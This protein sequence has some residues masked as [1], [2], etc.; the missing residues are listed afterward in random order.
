MGE[1]LI[2]SLFAGRIDR[3]I[4]EII[5]VDQVS[6]DIVK[7]EISEYVAT[8]SIRHHYTEIFERYWETLKR[9]HEGIAIWI[10]GFFG[11]GKSS[12]AKM[13]GLALENRNIQGEGAADLIAQRIGDSRINVLLKNIEEYVPTDGLIF[14]VSTDRGIRSG[15]QTLTEIIYRL[16]LQRLGYARD[17][18]LAE[19]EITLEAEKRLDQ[20]KECYAAVFKKDWDREK[21]K[22]A[23]AISEAS[24]VMQELN[25]DLYPAADSWVTAAKGRADITPGML[26]ERC[27]ELLDRRRPGRSFIFVI[28]E[29]GQFVARDIQKM[30]DLQAIVQSLGRVGRGRMWIAVTSQEKLNELVGGLDDKRV[31]LARLR[32]RFSLEVHLEPSD[33]SE[34]TGKRVLSKK[35]EA[36][37][38]LRELFSEYR[39][40]LTDSTRLTA[41]VKLPELA[42]ESFIDLYPLLPYQV[43]LIIQVVSG[44]RTQGGSSKH[45]GG[46]NR[47]IIKLA[48]QIL[49][50]PGVNLA[51]MP[52]GA[53]ARIDQIYDL[54]AGNIAS[55]LRSKIDHIASQIPHPLSAPVAKAICLLQFVKSIHRTP[56]NI[57]ATLHP[58]VD[59]DSRLPE[60]REALKALEKA[61]MV[62][63]GEDGY[64]IP[65][66]AEDDWERQRANLSPKPGDIMRIHAE[67]ASGLWQPQPSF[68]FLKTKMFKAGLFFNAKEEVQGDIAF[69][70]ALAEEGKEYE[71]L[72][73]Q[74]RARSQT[75]T[76]SI[77]WAGAVGVAI[78]KETVEFFRSRE[79]LSKKERGAQTKDET[80]LV[81]EERKALTRHRDELKRLI[82]QTLLAG[83][84]FFRGNERNPGKGATELTQAASNLL[85]QALP[86]VFD[87]FQDAASQVQRKDLEAL[88]TAENL[89][90]LTPVF[91]T[92]RLIMDQGGRP[93]FNVDSG[94][95]YEVMAKIEHRTSY[96]ETA[97]GRYLCDEFDRDPFGWD[98]EAVRLFVVSL[99]R[100]GKIEATS[101]G[102]LIES[103][104]SVEAQNTFIN[105]NLFRQ[106]SFRPKVGLEFIHLIKAGEN[107]KAAF[108]KEIPVLE[109]GTAAG[110]IR[111]EVGS[112]EKELNEIRNQ[113]ASRSLPGVEVIQD[114]INHIH[115]IRTGKED[116]AI[117]EF[118][119]S[120]KEIK[121]AIKRAAEL[122]AELTEP[123]LYILDRARKAIREF[124]PFLHQEND[125]SED[126]AKHAETLQDLLERETFYREF[127]DIEK[128]C[129][130]VDEEYQNRYKAAAEDRARKYEAAVLQMEE[131]P[132]WSELREEQRRLIVQPL[133]SR[134]SAKLDHPI[135]VPTLRADAD[136]VQ[137]RLDKA[138]KEMML[139]LEGERVV[140]VKAS[141]FFKGGIETEEQLESALKGLREECE[142]LIGAGKKILVN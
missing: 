138:I 112:H 97:S 73:S 74:F 124:W 18:D 96:G 37:K 54:V 72:L 131:T 114:A 4:E 99:L 133:A 129:R 44:L 76:K 35:A 93:I 29:V 71:I 87:R 2:K 125:L 31:E 9:P 86:E 77:F 42:A 64:R 58:S 67:V 57:T 7:E 70:L 88:L 89:R 28:D 34:V 101:K 63:L 106:A 100:A 20:F 17:I 95:L 45:V 75:E 78:D 49:I 121:E 65:S 59:A 23:F 135:P 3:R 43:D 103:V 98:F 118:N 85:S 11:S 60:V 107:F 91:A 14:D 5:K 116:Q 25:P 12:F 46:A 82:K 53:L 10:S 30:L 136:A 24:R 1:K 126:F 50:H 51:E 132:G 130:A 61:H 52:L 15:N 41:D 139:A 119:T 111:T 113:M 33:I 102:Q 79:I 40:R 27:K 6:E 62:R 120:F 56:E 140:E 115:A 127:P 55:E 66:P 68:N 21:G 13:L 105:N 137:A 80:A 110:C 22:V 36:Q 94:P 117:L 108:G 47:T 134:A 48:Q 32:D 8:N 122:M 16:F 128:H 92:L 26:A 69:H 84:A 81:A 19:L 90:G 142:P 109:Q 123:H 38:V 83:T 104:T 141:K 39:G